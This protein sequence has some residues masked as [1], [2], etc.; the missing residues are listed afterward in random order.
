MGQHRVRPREVAPLGPRA[1]AVE[2]GVQDRHDRG[3]ERGDR[4]AGSAPHRTPAAPF[5]S[6]ISHA[7]T[8]AAPALV[9]AFCHALE[10]R[11][12]GWSVM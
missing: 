5:A 9:A 4:P 8:D 3:A 12:S 10:V 6:L 11:S 1:R 7:E 2:P